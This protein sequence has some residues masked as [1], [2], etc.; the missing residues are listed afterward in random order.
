MFGSKDIDAQYPYAIYI[1]SDVVLSL[2]P[3][4]GY[5]SHLLLK[6]KT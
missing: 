4:Y 1:E 3:I 5:F 6:F 2:E